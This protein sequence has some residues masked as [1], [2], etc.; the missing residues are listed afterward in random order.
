MMTEAE[1]FQPLTLEERYT[2]TP[3]HR[4][5]ERELDKSLQPRG[6]DMLF[7]MVGE[8][9]LVSESTILDVGCGTGWAACRLAA[10]TPSRILAIDVV[11]SLLATTR[12]AVREAGLDQRITVQ[13][14]SILA[15]PVESNSLDLVWCR[16]M[17][18]DGF[19][20]PP[21]VQECCRV[22]RPGGAML[23]YKTFA[24]ESLEPREAARLLRGLG[25]PPEHLS[26]ELERM[27]T[28]HAERA[29]LDAG[30]GIERKD[31]IG[32][33]WREYEWEHGEY[34]PRHGLSAS[35]LLRQQDHFVQ[36]YGKPLYEQALADALWFPFIML[37]KLLPVA[38]LLRKDGSTGATSAGASS[39]SG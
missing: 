11:P 21:A 29:F 12:Q 8:L 5:F 19:P 15:L 34:G 33:E 20:I 13:E 30:L 26:A 18:G 24:G 16:D 1:E 4:Q 38:Y 3:E 2:S 6:P 14:A 32:G 27:S 37:G 23:V 9:H 31:V 10:R 25:T 17:L 22:L 7:A 28:D 39:R 35:R 36:K